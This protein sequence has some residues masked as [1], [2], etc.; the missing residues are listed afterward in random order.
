MPQYVIYARKSTESDDR[1][2]LSIQSQISELERI[3]A[4][5]GVT[6]GEVLTESKSAKAPGRPVFNALFR[7]VD[8]GGIGGILCW[9][10]DRLARNHYDAG[11][12]MQA[13]AEKKIER[14]ITSDGIK[15]SN[16]NDRFMG[17]IE[18]GAATKFI[19]DLS[20]NIRRGQ[21]ARAEKGW[22][23][24]IPP[25]GYLNDRLTKTIV[26]DPERFDLVQR[27]WQLLLGNSLRVDQIYRIAADELGL[28]TRPFGRSKGRTL[29][30]SCIYRLFA[31]PFY[32]GM[33]KLR[34]SGTWIGSHPPM[35]TRE[36]F[37]R[38]QE[39][40]GRPDRERPKKRTFAYAGL[41][42][43]GMCGRVL[44]G[45]Q[46]HNPKG[47]PYVYYRCSGGHKSVCKG[48][49]I[50]EP[51][52]ESQLS[53]YLRR[54]TIPQPVLAFLETRVASTLSDEIRRRTVVRNSLK[55]ALTGIRREEENLLSLRLRDLVDDPSFLAKRKGLQDQR[56]G[57]E[58]RVARAD[59]STAAPGQT[60]LQIADFAARVGS[61]FESGTV[62][63][64]RAIIEAV[65]AKSTVQAKKVALE[66]KIPFQQVAD[67]GG[68]HNWQ[69]LIH[70]VRKW[71]DEKTEFF[72]LPD[73][74]AEPVYG[75]LPP[76]GLK[77]KV[78]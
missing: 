9:K 23:N 30:K 1:Q 27:L 34:S 78:A 5:E 61:V 33:I 60:L 16:G 7:R 41:L 11:V 40:L 39:I 38:V 17:L 56:R 54:L 71:L 22:C 26:K 75:V 72:A 57:M 25:I 47:P 37:D 3:A 74:N 59:A 63:Q 29:S 68:I 69:C 15:T 21:R 6:V 19:D 42:K 62:F 4:R 43:C 55:T 2:V 66:F 31:N 70:D 65:S 64:R 53:G 77:N 44:V 20:A 13:L 73:L 76:L 18:L 67:S 45:E 24:G 12:I 49:S 46:H 58:D 8:E 35:A 52:L 36:E 51:A 10:L 50:S 28:R 48:K 14:I 32:M